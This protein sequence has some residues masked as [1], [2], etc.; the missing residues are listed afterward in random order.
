MWVIM[1]LHAPTGLRGIA[2]MYVLARLFGR[3]LVAN[4][5]PVEHIKSFLMV[6]WLELLNNAV[7]MLTDRFN[8]QC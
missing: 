6:R 5:H 2:A 8:L 1:I 4:H 7:I 3:A